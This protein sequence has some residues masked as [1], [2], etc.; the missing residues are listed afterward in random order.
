MLPV[1]F[2]ALVIGGRAMGIGEIAIAVIIIAAIV[3]VV[4]IVLRKMNIPI[5]DWVM[6]IFWI[7]VIAFVGV[8]AVKL[9]LSM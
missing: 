6:Q 4:L 2:A 5:A 8:C 3:A 1:L 7:L 9:L